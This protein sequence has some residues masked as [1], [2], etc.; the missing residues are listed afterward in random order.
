MRN[1]ALC[2]R[3]MLLAPL[4]WAVTAH[5]QFGNLGKKADAAKKIAYFN[6]HG[7]LTETPVKIPPLFGEEPPLSLKA[8]LERFKQ[9]RQDNSVV[10]VVLDLQGARLG[11]GQLEEIHAALRKFNAVDKE[12]FVH[13]DTLS[14]GTFAAATGASHIS[15]VPTGDLWLLGLYGETPYLRG[16]LDKLGITPDFEHLEAYKTAHEFYTMIGPSEAAREMDDWLLDGLYAGLVDMVAE[17]RE[18]SPE[19]IR[20]L[21][22]DGPYSAEAAL[23]A[24]LIDSVQHRQ[25]FV[26]D[27]KDRYGRGVEVVADYAEEEEALPEDFFSMIALFMEMLNPQPKTYTEPSVAVIYVEGAIQTGTQEATPFGV[28][29]GAF[30]TSIRKALDKAAEDRSVKAVVLRVDSGGGS[31]LASEII[32]DAAQRVARRKPLIASMGNVA[33]SGG[34]YVLCGAETI[35]SDRNTIAGSIGVVG[36][37][38]VT[39]GGWNKLGINW[40]AM[41]RG[42]MAALLSTA[43]P[44]NEQ[45][46]AKILHYMTTIYDKFKAHV[47]EGRGDRLTKPVEEMAGGRVFTGEQALA[48]GLIDK[49]GGLDDA[50]KFA[51][52]RAGLGE[53]EI[54]VIPEPPNV[55]EMLFAPPDEDD[56]FTRALAPANP[57]LADTPLFRTFLPALGKVD[58]LRVQAILYQLQFL[59]L[60]DKEG[61]ITMMPG[62]LVIR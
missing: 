45:E 19:K 46:R 1:S 38:L 16:A 17:G 9:A 31:A 13:A 23:A 27:L 53:Y 62:K 51:A 12:V 28:A 43:T 10:A 18:M 55:L 34:Y 49:I 47:N 21:I 11:L 61:V 5:A 7:Q 56:E 35:F 59:E 54:R 15:L 42:K 37:K 50:I 25:D 44:F 14:T 8:L 39:T 3:V 48:L 36:G 20:A 57:S 33:A 4:V 22:D 52:N 58:P 6:I 40:H 41:Q 60:L 29:G 32:W 2:S 30:S 26:A 24:G